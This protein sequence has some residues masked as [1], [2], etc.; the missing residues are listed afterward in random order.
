MGFSV[1]CVEKYGI[2]DVSKLCVFC[3]FDYFFIDFIIILEIGINDF[4]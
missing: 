3:Y 1:N 2:F 4:V